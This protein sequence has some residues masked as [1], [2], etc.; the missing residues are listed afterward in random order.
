MWKYKG[1]LKTNMNHNHAPSTR[2]HEDLGPNPFAPEQQSSIDR[3]DTRPDGRFRKLAKRM[4]ARINKMTSITIKYDQAPEATKVTGEQ[5]GTDGLPVV[6][7]FAESNA[8]RPSLEELKLNAA[9]HTVETGDRAAVESLLAEDQAFYGRVAERSV[10][11]DEQKKHEEFMQHAFPERTQP[12]SA[13]D[14]DPF[15]GSRR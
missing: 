3:T 10:A 13:G 12:K 8:P 14:F 4:G 1:T 11:A 9:K 7:P 5:V 15:A 6:N 2:T